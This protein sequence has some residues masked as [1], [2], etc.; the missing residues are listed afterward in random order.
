LVLGTDPDS[1]RLEAKVV[2]KDGSATTL[3]SN[4]LWPIVLEEW[5]RALQADGRLPT[6]AIVVRSF[7]TSS[8]IDKVA[9][10]FGI[11]SIETPT[12][13]KWIAEQMTTKTVLG[14]FEESNGMSIGTHTR[15]KCAQL[16]AVM[17]AWTAARGASRGMSLVDMRDDQHR[18]YGKYEAKTLDLS[19]DGVEGRQAMGKIKAVLSDDPKRVFPEDGVRIQVL[20]AG[21][22]ATRAHYKD[23]TVITVRPS[24]TEP[25]MKVYVESHGEGDKLAQA[26]AQRIRTLA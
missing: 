14:G 11:A 26:V 21:F 10:A 7:V 8:L 9:A 20:E 12:G 22:D 15:E 25:K 18:R 24:G 17:V 13:F 4:D 5:L 1:D 23:G 19:F 6:D 16:A 3:P 2:G